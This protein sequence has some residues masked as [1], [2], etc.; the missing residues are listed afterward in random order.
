MVVDLDGR[1]VAVFRVDGEF[2]A[3][4]NYCVHQGGPVCEGRLSGTLAEAPDG[5]LSY[6]HEGGVVACPWHGWE[7]DVRTGEA[8]ADPNYRQPTYDVVVE[9]GAVYVEA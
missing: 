2:L 5:T 9:A 3:L 4:A 7:F 8:L 6:D 1:E